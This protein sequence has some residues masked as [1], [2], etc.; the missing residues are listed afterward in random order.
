MARTLRLPRADGTLIAYRLTGATPVTPPA[1]PIRCRIAYAAVHVVADPLA[2]INP[3][4]E[5]AL[6]W[7]ATLAYRRYIWSLGLAVAEAMDT[8]QRGMGFDWS[9]AKELIRRA[10][11]EARGIPGAVIAS[12]AGTD[13]LEPGQRVTLADVEAA[14]EEQCAVIESVGCPIILIASRALAACAKGGDDYA[15]VYGKLLEQVSEPVIIHWL[16]QMFDPALA[17]H[18]GSPDLDRATVK[19]VAIVREQPAKVGSVEILLLDQR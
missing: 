14:Y 17:R 11:A 15:K 10:V 6:D 19:L 12:G 3:T 5:T 13:H 1:G 4:L 8:S 18:L 16:G 7:E 9:T 2:A